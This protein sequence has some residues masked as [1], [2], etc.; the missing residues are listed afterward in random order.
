M[1]TI[2]E[3]LQWKRV[4]DKEAIARDIGVVLRQIMSMVVDTSGRSDHVLLD[5]LVMIHLLQMVNDDS[6]NVPSIMNSIGI[7]DDER[8]G[9]CRT[10]SLN[11]LVMAKCL[12]GKYKNNGTCTCSR[13]EIK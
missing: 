4:D 13:K 5:A 12:F 9:F 7:S 1:A 11:S 10:L 3:I 6:E 2:H 8:A